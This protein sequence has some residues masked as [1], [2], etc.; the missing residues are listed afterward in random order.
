MSKAKKS[1]TSEEKKEKMP[2]MASLVFSPT[3]KVPSVKASITGRGGKKPSRAQK[4]R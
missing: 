3:V 2:S 1:R 4:K